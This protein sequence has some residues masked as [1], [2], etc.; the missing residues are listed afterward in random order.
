MAEPLVVAKGL[1]SALGIIIPMLHQ[2]DDGDDMTLEIQRSISICQDAMKR[3]EDKGVESPTIQQ[4]IEEVVDQLRRPQNDLHVLTD[5]NSEIVEMLEF[6]GR[7]V[8]RG[9][10]LHR[11]HHGAES[12]RPKEVAKEVAKG[13][14][15]I[16]FGVVACGPTIAL[17]P[18]LIPAAFVAPQ[19]VKRGLICATGLDCTAHQL[20]AKA[21]YKEMV[22]VKDKLRA[23]LAMIPADHAFR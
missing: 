1:V 19:Y 7:V 3:A 12:T 13:A 5:L 15:R 20:N 17:A 8:P 9:S 2:P 4:A 16:A 6:R 10:L 14:G 22:S 21:T 11:Y 23:I 18:L